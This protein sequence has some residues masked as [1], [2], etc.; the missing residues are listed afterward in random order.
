M[1]ATW[2]ATLLV[3]RLGRRV[4]LLFS[5][6]VMMLCLSLLTAY[7]Y[8]KVDLRMDLNHLD[9][10]PLISLCVYMFALSMGMAPLPWLLVGEIF[11]SQIRGCACSVACLFNWIC[12]FVVTKGLT[13]LAPEIGMAKVFALFTVCCLVGFAYIYVLLPE[14][15]GKSLE[16]I[17]V[18]LDESRSGSSSDSRRKSS[19]LLKLT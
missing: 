9:R 7:F 18:M 5:I 15:K 11:P 19:H 10:L 17:R 14:T 6:F 1:V 8:T 13:S 4:L 2:V 16:Q 12:V 3:D